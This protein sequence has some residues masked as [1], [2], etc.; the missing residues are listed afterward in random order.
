MQPLLA[1]RLQLQPCCKTRSS[2]GQLAEYL[3]E[4][5][6]AHERGGFRPQCRARFDLGSLSS[7]WLIWPYLYFQSCCL[8]WSQGSFVMQAGDG[9]WPGGI[10]IYNSLQ[11]F[12]TLG[13]V[14]RKG[15]FK[16]NT[17]LNP[18][19][20]LSRHLA[21]FYAGRTCFDFS[22]AYGDLA[23]QNKWLLKG[24][25]GHKEM[26]RQHAKPWSWKLRRYNLV[27]QSWS[28]YQLRANAN[29]FWVLPFPRHFCFSH[30]VLLFGRADL[31]HGPFAVFLCIVAVQGG[32][33]CNNTPS[34]FITNTKS[35]LE[36]PQVPTKAGLSFIL[37]SPI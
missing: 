23:L 33:R 31:S 5:P 36:Y 27:Q 13:V 25:Q 24:R 18:C 35:L 10:S 15:Q 28:K 21:S 1:E 37:L 16:I 20:R 7:L 29:L 3:H 30:I 14:L 22:K 9:I 17:G 6:S 26:T 8:L 11:L 2:S 4:I 32:L 12:P 34:L 19:L